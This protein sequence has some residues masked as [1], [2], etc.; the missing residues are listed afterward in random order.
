MRR[1]KKWLALALI[2]AMMVSTQAMLWAAPAEVN[3]VGAA[4]TLPELETPL[5][6]LKDLDPA[7]EGTQDVQ[8]GDGQPGDNE[9][10]GEKG[11]KDQSLGG[12][13]GDQ[14]RTDADGSQDENDSSKDNQT[15][16]GKIDSGQQKIEE[17]PILGQAGVKIEANSLLQNIQ[18]TAEK[19]VTID[20]ICYTLHAD[21]LTAEVTGC[22]SKSIL[23]AT[24]L[25]IPA[26]VYD[27][28]TEYAVTAIAAE[29]MTDMQ[30]SGMIQ[31]SLPEGL[32]SIGDYAFEGV[33]IKETLRIP[34]SVTYLGQ[35][36]FIAGFFEELII[37]DGLTEIPAKA[38]AAGFITKVELG[39]GIQKIASDAF[40]QNTIEQIIIHG[41]K[42]S[43]DE[44]LQQ[45]EGLSKNVSIRYLDPSAMDGETLQTQINEA[46]GQGQVVIALTSDV[47]LSKTITV[48]NGADIVLIDDGQ[49]QSRNI[50]ALPGKTVAQ[51][52]SVAA[53]GKLT[54]R[55]TGGD[56]ALVLEGSGQTKSR[57]QASLVNVSGEFCLEGGT[58]RG[59]DI[60]SSSLAG[61]ILL[62]KEAHF[63]M[64]GGVIEQ[65]R[66]TAST[67]SLTGTVVVGPGALFEMSGGSI[68]NNISSAWNQSSGGGVLIYTWSQNDAPGVMCLSDD[69]EI[70]GNQAYDGAGIYLTGNADLKMSGGTIASNTAGHFGGGVCVA[71]LNGGMPGYTD[72]PCNF[73]MTG[74]VIE[75]NQ[76]STGGG[77]YVN[78]NGV[79]LRA[80]LIADNRATNQGGGI[81]V[82]TVPY[83]LHLSNAVITDNTAAI[84]GGGMWF[85]PTGDAVNHVTNGGAVFANHSDGA[86]DDF[87]A[88][89]QTGKNHRVTL[90][91]RMLGGGEV[92][93]YRDGGIAP[94]GVL[95]GNV[96]G[97]PNGSSRYAADDS[98]ER[99]IAI[100]EETRGLALKALVSEA[101]QQLALEQAT[102]QITGNSALRGGG[103]GSNGGMIIGEKDEWTLTVTKAWDGVD[104]AD[105]SE[106]EITIYLKIGDY[107]LDG[108]TLNQA[109]QWTAQFTQLP[110]PATLEDLSISVLEAGTL[111]EASYSAVA[112]DEAAKTLAIT[113]TNRP[114]AQLTG[115][116]TVSKRVSG[117]GADREKAFAFTVTLDD[118]TIVGK[119]GDMTFADGVAQ[120]TLKHGES[121]TAAALPA[122][123][124]YT[125]T[126]DAETYQATAVGEQGVIQDKTTAQSV[127]NN[128]KGG[129]GTPPS[130]DT[131]TTPDT[132]PAPEDPQQPER[133][134]TDEDVPLTKQPDLPNGEAPSEE[135]ILPDDVPLARIT[136]DDNPHTGTASTLPTAL[137][138][139]TLAGAAAALLK[140][141]KRRQA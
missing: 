40:A 87:V 31:L 112:I 1:W 84:L 41:Q 117:S 131:P 35:G 93:W 73:L 134:I 95:G 90:A 62:N 56:E 19:E 24:R 66:L 3:P 78:S 11:D 22:N 28:D 86:G 94:N 39:S 69:A 133:P 123:V 21:D 120:F 75:G 108:I 125:V 50:T 130:P 124:H 10:P 81:Y 110:N 115:N 101:A 114:K 6:Q 4:D 42:G 106:Q 116:L 97:E 53:G 27:E 29:A 138:L 25:D 79:D 48:P 89:P 70:T 18:L 20:D 16:D 122:G 54:L 129:G 92:Q 55:T 111:Y 61:A 83:T 118:S 136:N 141:I 109:N 102:L 96:L 128:Y 99:L 9:E 140:D 32:R 60:S 132:P 121:K 17:E 139:L 47:A 38:F 77:V 100:S 26:C 72:V 51:L 113:V 127:F 137:G 8:P 68:R 34:D 63:A 5:D 15:D 30:Y 104:E 33:L 13:D 119:Y 74:G 44:S 103:I 14:Q 49:G 105:Y 91:D 36:A 107:Q 65:T 85:C 71:G 80:G 88:V 67:G 43:L 59:G 64:T 46:V 126:E 2:V 98:A 45:L 57:N 7:L 135:A 23:A 52:F 58:L 12:T 76:A 37:G 82:S